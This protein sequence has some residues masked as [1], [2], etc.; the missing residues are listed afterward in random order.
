MKDNTTLAPNNQLWGI[1]Y[2]D[3]EYAREMGDPLRTF[4][5]APT[6]IAAE[7]AAARLGFG[8][9]CVH[10]VTAEQARQAQWLPERLGNHQLRFGRKHFHGIRV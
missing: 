6:K 3:H 5:D 8:D 1:Y 9:A 2:A 7:Q 4:V 10:P